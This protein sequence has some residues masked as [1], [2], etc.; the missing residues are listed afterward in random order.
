MRVIPSVPDRAQALKLRRGSPERRRRR[1]EGGLQ[2][3]RQAVVELAKPHAVAI[4][5]GWGEINYA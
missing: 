3:P 1:D 2:P 4:H 5:R